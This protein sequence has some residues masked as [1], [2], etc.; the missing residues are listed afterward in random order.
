MSGFISAAMM[1]QKSL[2]KAF[3]LLMLLCDQASMVMLEDLQLWCLI[4]VSVQFKHQDL[5][6]LQIMQAPLYAK[7][8][9]NEGENG[10]TSKLKL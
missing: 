4:C 5:Y 8:T 1:F 9:E 2:S 10:S 6:M 3:I 7:Q